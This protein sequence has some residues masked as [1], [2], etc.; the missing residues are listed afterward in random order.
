MS[1]TQG[2]GAPESP[3]LFRGCGLIDCKTELIGLC[4]CF[5]LATAVSTWSLY[6]INIVPQP[7]F[8]VLSTVLPNTNFFFF[9]K[10]H[11]KKKKKKKET[12]VPSSAL[13]GLSQSSFFPQQETWLGLGFPLIICLLSQESK[14]KGSPGSRGSCISRE[15]KLG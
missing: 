2:E 7:F 9:L 4:I 3:P 11:L 1:R 15:A 14:L 12:S 6:R 8:P 5:F 10:K 13:A